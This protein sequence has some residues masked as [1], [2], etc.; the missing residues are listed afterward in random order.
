MTKKTIKSD[1]QQDII[2]ELFLQNWE[3]KLKRDLTYLK[4]LQKKLQSTQVI[5]NIF[6]S[7]KINSIKTF[8]FTLQN[9]ILVIAL[10][11]FSLYSVSIVAV[12]SQ[13]RQQVNLVANDSSNVATLQDCDLSVSFP[14]KIEGQDTYLRGAN[15]KA[16]YKY[17]DSIKADK[18]AYENLAVQNLYVG[19][20]TSTF[21]PSNSLQDLNVSC[22]EIKDNFDYKKANYFGGDYSLYDSTSTQR[23]YELK[24]LNT[25][26]FKDETK[27]LIADSSLEN[28]KIYKSSFTSPDESWIVQFEKNNKRYFISFY[29]SQYSGEKKS[30]LEIKNI[31]SQYNFQFDSVAK[32]VP[33]KNLEYDEFGQYQEFGV[34]GSSF[35]KFLEKSSSFIYEYSWLFKILILIAI[36]ALVYFS[37]V[38]FIKTTKIKLDK[39][40]RFH[41]VDFLLNFISLILLAFTSQLY[42]ITN[43]G[44]D[45][46]SILFGWQVIS[47]LIY[48]YIYFKNK[49][50]KYLSIHG[51]FLGLTGLLFIIIYILNV[52]SLFWISS[53]LSSATSIIVMFRFII[54]FFDSLHGIRTGKDKETTKEQ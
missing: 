43:F 12:S 51:I 13:S 21:V 25:T 29:T 24:N 33:N 16:Y 37:M 30:N 1:Q 49:N 34:G 47:S 7:L 14:K 9:F 40:Q 38:I 20:S 4:L 19:M 53:I 6:M 23:N 54:L 31:L 42:F 44:Y 22:G 39:L 28:I 26:Q 45:I 27:W 52:N 5:N 50:W 36:L 10:S 46:Y 41:L 3:F 32:S 35:D 18:N 8:I 11:M 2:S 17:L 48:G 15:R